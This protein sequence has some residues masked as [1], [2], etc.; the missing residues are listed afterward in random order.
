MAVTLSSFRRLLY[1]TGSL[2]GDIQAVRRGP[3]AVVRRMGRKAAG[4][5]FGRVMRGAG[6]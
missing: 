1:R 3:K 2:L 5:A 6:L 4:R